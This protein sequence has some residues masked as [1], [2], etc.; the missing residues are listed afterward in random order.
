MIK[1]KLKKSITNAI[2]ESI[3]NSIDINIS[4]PIL[5]YIIHSNILPGDFIDIPV[6]DVIRSKIYSKEQT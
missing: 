6:E 1:A 4:N 2:I 5:M 3:S